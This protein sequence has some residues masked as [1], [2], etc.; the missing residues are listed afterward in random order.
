M[1]TVAPFIPCCDKLKADIDDQQIEL[2]EGMWNVNG[3]CAVGCYVASD[4][5]FCPY[6]GTRLS[7]LKVVVSGG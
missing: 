4:I 3:C 5:K 7:E 1:T 2:L 6:C